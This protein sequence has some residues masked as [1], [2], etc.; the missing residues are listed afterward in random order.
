M[1]KPTDILKQEHRL[2]ERMLRVVET[3][4]TRLEG[5]QKVNPSDIERI[6][7]FIRNFADKCHHG[8]EEDLYFVRIHQRGVPKE[9]GP[10]GVMLMEH[11]QGR[12]FVR[13]MAEHLED[14]RR[15]VT[16]GATAIAEGAWG[17]VN[18]LREHIQKEDHIL[19]PMGDRV[20][21]SEDQQELL[22]R[23][24]EVEE[25]LMGPGVH[26]AYHRLVEE[27]EGKYLEGR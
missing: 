6:I 21:S 14:Y 9:G 11:D 8:K 25:K 27:L 2:I 24:Q 13:Q 4:A 15:G 10:I 5:S 26:E 16:T 22:T 20:L 3:V 18:L 23:F 1:T 19:Y 17:Y 7:D 12:G